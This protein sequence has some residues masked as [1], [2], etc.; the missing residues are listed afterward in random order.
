[1][2]PSFANGVDAQPTRWRS[3]GQVFGVALLFGVFLSATGAIDTEAVPAP[4][5]LLYWIGIALLGLISANALHSML[6]RRSPGWNPPLLRAVGWCALVLPCTLVA[7]LTCKL[8]FGGRPSLAGFALLL[9]AIA[10]ILAV[11]QLALSLLERRHAVAAAPNAEATLYT[12]PADPLPVPLPLR[13]ARIQAL[14][15]EDHYVRVYTDAGQAL[16]RMRMRDARVALAD[17]DGVT[18]HRSWWVAREAVASLANE[19]GRAV[20][21]LR[22]GLTVPVSRKLRSTL[23]PAF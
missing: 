7:T 22:S 19:D 12:A 2:T 1:M 10:S 11:I 8:L 13:G 14:Q 23:G 15:A 21:T 18:P 17:L 9:P 6:A 20:L 4:P 5:R 16:V 3:A